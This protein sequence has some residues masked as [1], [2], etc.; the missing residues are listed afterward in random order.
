MMKLRPITLLFLVVLAAAPAPALPASTP[1]SGLP[2]R[3]AERVDLKGY[4]KNLF[5][6]SESASGEVFYGDLNRHRL[7]LDASISEG[8]R[9]YAAYDNEIIAGSVL[10]TAEFSAAR[11]MKEAN[12][13]D[14]S[15]ATLDKDD[16]F[17]LQR[18]YRAY[19]RYSRGAVSVTAGRQRVPLGT[20]RIWNPEDL[21]D[22]ISPLQIE[23]DE[24]PGTDAVNIEAEAGPLSATTLVFAPGRASASESYFIR[25]RLNRA[26]YD[27]SGLAG[28]FRRDKTLGFDFS[29]YIKDSGL[30]G[31]FAYTFA[32]ERGDFL[33]AVASFDHNFRSGLYLV[34][35]Y[36]FNGGNDPD[37]ASTLTAVTASSE[38]L[39]LNRNFIGVGAG[40]DITPLLRFEGLSVLD[41]EG[42]SAFIG[43]SLRYNILENLDLSAGVQIFTGRDGSEYGSLPELFYG[44][45]QLYF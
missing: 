38:I 21:L 3:I 43:P 10:D 13:F 6:A 19:V 23:R 2:A 37:V 25:H 11:E 9:A 12:F 18:I 4:Y 20:G 30:R 32:G 17:W 42:K 34:I 35:E 33:R 29:G 14:L 24:R 15:A 41:I 22:P 26:G 16:I 8:L 27:F 39:T 44:E 5:T 7:E 1:L 36:L 45:L 40:Y 28:V 31:E